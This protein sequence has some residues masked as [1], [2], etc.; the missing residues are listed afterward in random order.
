[1]IEVKIPQEIRQYKEKL[2][3]LLTLRQAIASGF[4]V[5]G[6]VLIWYLTKDLELSS[7][8]MFLIIGVFAVP[9]GLW[10]WYTPN[11]MPFEEFVV[12]VIL[13]SILYPSVRVY[14]TECLYENILDE[15]RKGEV[16]DHVG[17][18]SEEG[19]SEKPTGKGEAAAQEGDTA[20]G[21][22]DNTLSANI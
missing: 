20:Y 13:S 8:A 9:F 17:E 14:K 15:I 11:G 19:R 22:A 2:F 3:G 10:G 4:V 18:Q 16:F 12:V 21:S 7:D 6:A 1:M 5:G